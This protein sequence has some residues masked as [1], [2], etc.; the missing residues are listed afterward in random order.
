MVRVDFSQSRQVKDEEGG[1]MFIPGTLFALIGFGFILW[2]A[3]TPRKNFG[4][5]EKYAPEG[6]TIVGGIIFA[7]GIMIVI[8]PSI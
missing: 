1:N 6:L 3:Y 2:G 8:A 4:V 5:E 7:I